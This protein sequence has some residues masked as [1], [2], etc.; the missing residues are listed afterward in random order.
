L[1]NF[2]SVYEGCKFV[3]KL[4]RPKWSFIESVP[5]DGEQGRE[6]DDDR[7]ENLETNGQPS[8]VNVTK[9][10]INIFGKKWAKIDKYTENF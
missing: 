4:F 8:G 1:D 7:A 5:D 3:R 2:S 6:Q 9:Y 10:F